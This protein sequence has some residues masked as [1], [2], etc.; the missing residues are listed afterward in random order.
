M[1]DFR[2]FYLDGDKCPQCGTAA[3][4]ELEP[5]SFGCKCTYEFEHTD[6]KGEKNNE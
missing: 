2:D 1:S 5:N 6:F 4:Y 3:I